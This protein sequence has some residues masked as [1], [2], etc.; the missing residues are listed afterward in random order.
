[1]KGNEAELNALRC[2]LSAFL[3]QIKIKRDDAIAYVK[4]M[5]GVLQSAKSSVDNFAATNASSGN[6]VSY[7]DL[8]TKINEFFVQ[9]NEN[10]W[11]GHLYFISLQFICDQVTTRVSALSESYRKF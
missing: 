5:K 1:M 10:H 3:N 8:R 6:S 2:E 7:S 9:F 11:K 4:G